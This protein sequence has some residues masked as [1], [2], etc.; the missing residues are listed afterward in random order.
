MDRRVARRHVD[1]DEVPPIAVDDLD[2]PTNGVSD[3]KRAVSFRGAL[4][5]RGL[6]WIG[7]PAASEPDRQ[8][9]R[10]SGPSSP[11]ARW[12]H[13]YRIAGEA[14]FLADERHAAAVELAVPRLEHDLA[15][16]GRPHERSRHAHRQLVRFGVLAAPEGRLGER[17]GAVE[18]AHEADRVVVA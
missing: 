8:R 3:A 6:G 11:S 9:P 2:A 16:D 5:P 15:V 10:S 18:F 1:A 4:W 7:H 13:P 14:S 17:R 12:A